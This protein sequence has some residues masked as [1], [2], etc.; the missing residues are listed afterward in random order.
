MCT[1]PCTLS[2][3]CSGVMGLT[4]ALLALAQLVA[5]AWSWFLSRSITQV[6]DARVSLP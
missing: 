6:C 2:D 5:V 4:V 1:L 3:A